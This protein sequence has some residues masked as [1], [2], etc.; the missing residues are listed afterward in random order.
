MLI[1]RYYEPWRSQ[2]E[3]SL[4]SVLSLTLPLTSDH[5]GR[6]PWIASLRSQRQLL[7]YYR[8]VILVI[9]VILVVASVAKQSRAIFPQNPKLT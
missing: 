2:I 6:S 4:N 7:V 1:S 3:A 8:I 5:L 9:L